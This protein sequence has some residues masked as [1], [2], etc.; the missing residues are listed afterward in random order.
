MALP[1]LK[2]LKKH[3][4]DNMHVWLQIPVQSLAE[5][6]RTRFVMSH[7]QGGVG[8]IPFRGCCLAQMGERI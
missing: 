2:L 4:K 5:H 1:V 3:W 7:L 6:P 8:N